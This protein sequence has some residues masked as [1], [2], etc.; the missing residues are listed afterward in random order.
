MRIR[1]ALCLVLPLT[2]CSPLGGIQPDLAT[3]AQNAGA[4]CIRVK[5]LVM[6]DAVYVSINDTKNAIKNGSVTVNPDTC[7]MTL[8]NAPKDTTVAPVVSTT[9][10]SSTITTTI[11]PVP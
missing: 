9:T 4:S 10:G 1:P 11:K 3:A 7:A 8:N 2:A 5:S 6:G